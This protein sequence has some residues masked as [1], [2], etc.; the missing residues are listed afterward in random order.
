MKG[1][2]PFLESWTAFPSEVQP[3]VAGPLGTLREVGA[4]CQGGADGTE[5]PCPGLQIIHWNLAPR[6]QMALQKEGR[7]DCLIVLW[8][9]G[10]GLASKEPWQVWKGGSWGG[11]NGRTG[12]KGEQGKVPPSPHMLQ[13]VGE[14]PL[15][16]LG[17]Q[18]RL[19]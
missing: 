19:G 15:G 13:P 11:R 10:K 2:N 12:S 8:S 14:G 7:G 4:G 6:P 3:A 9:G 16:C 5:G 17:S 1:A 18:A